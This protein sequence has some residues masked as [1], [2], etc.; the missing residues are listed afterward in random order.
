MRDIPACLPEYMPVPLQAAADFH[1]V[2]DNLSGR[3]VAY[4]V[5][6]LWLAANTAC[7]QTE[8]KDFFRIPDN[9]LR[10]AMGLTRRESIDQDNARTARLKKTSIRA[11]GLDLQAPHAQDR[12]NLDDKRTW[13]VPPTLQTAWTVKDGEAVVWLPRALLM[14]AKSR[15]SVEAYLHAMALATGHVPVGAKL[16]KR[17]DTRVTVRMDQKAMTRF[18]GAGIRHSLYRITEIVGELERDLPAWADTI[19]ECTM[20]SSASPKF[21]K[22]RFM[23]AT[24]HVIHRP[25]AEM[26]ALGAGTETWVAPVRTSVPGWEMKPPRPRSSRPQYNRPRAADISHI[27]YIP[28]P[29][30][31]IS[32]RTKPGEGEKVDSNADFEF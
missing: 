3:D 26:E 22:G 18:L 16:E 30:R 8:G 14:K 25:I 29:E 32:P 31:P 21:P 15:F 2:G 13:Y 23:Y 11:G 5:A 1:V 24:I 17:I 27:A 4:S 6:A 20:R 19:V 28:E 12:H 9:G 7:R 10:H